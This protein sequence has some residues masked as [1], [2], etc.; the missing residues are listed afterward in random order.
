VWA[1]NLERAAE[2]AQAAER[3]NAGHLSSSASTGSSSAAS[4]SASFSGTDK[5]DLTSMDAP[6]KFDARVIRKYR[7]Y[8]AWCR[9]GFDAELLHVSRVVFEKI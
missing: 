6:F 5:Q 1:A 3:F 2:R 7:Y 8:L 4:A 9:A